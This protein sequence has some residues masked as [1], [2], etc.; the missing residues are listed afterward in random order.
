[1]C[2]RDRAG[3]VWVGYAVGEG[4]TTQENY[5]R[6]LP[7]KTTQ[8][9][10]KN[11][12]RNCSAAARH[13]KQKKAQVFTWAFSYMA[14]SAGFEPTTPAFGGQYSIQLSYECNAGAMIPI[15]GYGVHRLDPG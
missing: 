15:L 7:K 8:E 5:P 3:A 6:K 2:I 10:P 11:Y 14:H 9:L 1:M 12:P 4:V 13:E